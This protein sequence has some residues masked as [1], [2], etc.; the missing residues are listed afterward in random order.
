[1]NPYDAT[2]LLAKLSG[3]L[4]NEL[5]E[6][7]AQKLDY[8]PLALAGAAVFVKDIRQA[9]ASKHFGWDEC[10]K[11]LQKAKR[12]TTEDTLADT[13]PIYPN[14]MTTAITLAVEALVKSDKI[15]EHLIRFLS[16][17]APQPL[18]V[19]IAVSYLLNVLEHDDKE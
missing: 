19:D 9:K 1:M 6:N 2:S 8:Q 3:V 12:E 5:A 18:N 15:F 10:L 14:T 17:C 11:I 4:D 7:V 13:N 16:L